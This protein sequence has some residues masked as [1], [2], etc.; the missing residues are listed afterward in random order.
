MLIAWT[1]S[2]LVALY[3]EGRPPPSTQVWRKQR[4]ELE[5]LIWLGSEWV[6]LVTTTTTTTIMR[7]FLH[8]S[9]STLW[10][11]TPGL[12]RTTPS[13]S[14][15]GRLCWLQPTPEMSTRY[16]LLISVLILLSMLDLYFWFVLRLE[17]KAPRM[18]CEI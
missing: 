13:L 11:S 6:S 3:K 17:I 15:M 14:G 12:R 7:L 16:Y 2:A 9:S 10:G 8:S 4:P 1:S 5:S 18:C